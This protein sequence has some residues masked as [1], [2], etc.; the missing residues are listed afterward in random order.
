[1]RRV[2]ACTADERSTDGIYPRVNPPQ[3]CFLY[4]FL[5]KIYISLDLLSKYYIYINIIHL[6]NVIQ[7]IKFHIFKTFW[8]FDKISR[9]LSAQLRKDIFFYKLR[10]KKFKG[11]K[12]EGCEP[13]I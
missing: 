4:S 3:N 2:L 13:D 12:S 7:I 5:F 11:F 8:K 1:V 10:S 9:E 6:F